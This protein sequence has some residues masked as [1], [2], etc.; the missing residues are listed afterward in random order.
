MLVGVALGG[1][2][3]V[4]SGAGGL[5]LLLAAGVQAAIKERINSAASEL[6]WRNMEPP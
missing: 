3:F 5:M 4:A 6:L 1:R 2:V